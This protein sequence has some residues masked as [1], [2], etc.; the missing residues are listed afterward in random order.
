ME[1]SVPYHRVALQGNVLG[2]AIEEEDREGERERERERERNT[3][4]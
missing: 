3:H 2:G 1:I 4:I